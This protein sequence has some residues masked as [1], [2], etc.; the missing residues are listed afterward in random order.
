MCD[1]IPFCSVYL[2]VPYFRW[3]CGYGEEII[4]WWSWLPGVLSAR[5]AAASVYYG[6]LPLPS[7]TETSPTTP[8]HPSV[9]HGR[10]LFLSWLLPI[11]LGL[12]CGCMFAYKCGSSCL[13]PC[14]DVKVQV[15]LYIFDIWYLW[16][17]MINWLA[18]R[19][20]PSLYFGLHT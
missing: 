14:C 10:S 2:S 13:L 19:T 7:I 20:H 9:F 6:L 11:F 15:E 18:M 4:Q 8:R 16:W 1:S 5:A 3:C 17:I 12:C